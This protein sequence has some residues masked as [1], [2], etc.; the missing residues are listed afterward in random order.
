MESPFR[1]DST[2]LLTRAGER[3]SPFPQRH[4][5]CLSRSG[6]LGFGAY[7]AVIANLFQDVGCPPC[8]PAGSKSW[9][10]EVSRQTDRCQQHSRIKL[11]VGVKAA[12]R[13]LLLQ[14]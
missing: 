14:E 2:G 4:K 11:Y 1:P 8:Y 12:T 10:E 13:L 9:S 3:N 7:Q 6:I 5:M